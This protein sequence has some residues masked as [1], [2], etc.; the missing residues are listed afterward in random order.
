MRVRPSSRTVQTGR[1]EPTGPLQGH[2]R[3]AMPSAPISERQ[4]ID[5]HGA[6]GLHAPLT[7]AVGLLSSTHATTVC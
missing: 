4:Q 1:G 3:H 7:A 5:G 2:L 6:T